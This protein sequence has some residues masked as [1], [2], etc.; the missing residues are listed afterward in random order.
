M[1]KVGQ[2]VQ[3]LCDGIPLH[4]PQPVYIKTIGPKWI[5]TTFGIRVPAVGQHPHFSLRA[6]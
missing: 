4:Q 2:Q 3:Q 1:F 5:T 6:V